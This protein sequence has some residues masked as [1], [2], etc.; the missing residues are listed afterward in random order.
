MTKEDSIKNLGTIAKS[1]TS[2][3]QLWDIWLEFKYGKE[4]ALSNSADA[5]KQAYM[6]GKRVLKINPRH[7]IIKELQERVAKDLEDKSVKHTAEL[8]YQIVLMESG[9]VLSD[10][11]DFTS[12]IYGFMKNSLNISPDAALEEEDVVEEIKAESSVQEGA[13]NAKEDDKDIKDEL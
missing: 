1:G 2:D 3:I 13:Y 10:P 7:P 5:N 6:R 4:H 12:H 9:F 8:M 11:K